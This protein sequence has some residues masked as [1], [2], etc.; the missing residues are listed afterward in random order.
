MPAH[1]YFDLELL[2][3][4][5]LHHY[6]P[7]P[8]VTRTTVHEWP[9]SCV[10]LLTCQDGSQHIYKSQA[11]P[12]SVEAAVYRVNAAPHLVSA[13]IINDH[14]LIL[15]FVARSPLNQTGEEVLQQILGNIATMSRQTPVYR[16][17]ATLEQ[18]HECIHSTT[19]TLHELVHTQ[20]FHQL[21]THDIARINTIAHHVALHALWQGEIGI[22][23]GD[24]TAANML[25]TPTHTYVID[26]QRPLYAPT[27][28]DRWMLERTL[29]LPTTTPPHT[30]AL[31][32]M[33]E[34]AWLTDA[35]TRWF[36]AG[37]AHYDRQ[38]HALIQQL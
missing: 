25:H 38:I 30:K 21:T 10:Q 26:W 24:L 5:V 17:L 19:G 8:I 9:L 27:V 22:V 7:A 12:P 18:W 4:T 1:P 33:L 14:H 36:P 35:A 31:C 23:H 28:I 13:T 32:T 29:H 6:V 3:N 20:T 16:S 34:I 15:P 2:D 37:V 11:H